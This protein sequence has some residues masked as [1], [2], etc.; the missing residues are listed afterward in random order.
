MLWRPFSGLD[1]NAKASI[2]RPSTPYSYPPAYCRLSWGQAL[3]G[4]A[5]C[6]G[7]GRAPA[8][9]PQRADCRP[10]CR[11]LPP[12][13]PSCRRMVRSLRQLCG[14]GRPATRGLPSCSPPTRTTATTGGPGAT[15]C[16]AC[17]RK[18]GGLTQVAPALGCVCTSPIQPASGRCIPCVPCCACCAVPTCRRLLAEALGQEAAEQLLAAAAKAAEA[19]ETRRLAVLLVR[20]AFAAAVAQAEVEAARAAAGAPGGPK[21]HYQQGPV[22][23]AAAPVQPSTA[24]A[25]AAGEAAAAKPAELPG[26]AL[27]PW[28]LDKKGTA[29]LKLHANPSIAKLPPRPPAAGE[30]AP[31]EAAGAEGDEAQPAEASGGEQQAAAGTA[32]ELD[33]EA[34]AAA[35]AVAAAA[36]A[37]AEEQRKAERRRYALLRVCCCGCVAVLLPAQLH[38]CRRRATLATPAAPVSP[39]SLHCRTFHAPC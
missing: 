36:E 31:A 22:A 30:A 25:A 8:P 11:L 26:G 29:G 19:A 10:P 13:L 17:I 24:A 35:A 23:A 3:A 21:W 12:G 16:A 15:A 34:A 39:V 28:L 38:F 27:P 4:A 9:V 37:E 32:E 5:V 33:A 2:W 18:P 1:L 14:R 6:A 7:Q 20:S